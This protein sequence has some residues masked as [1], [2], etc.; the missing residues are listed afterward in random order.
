MIRPDPRA[1]DELIRKIE[2][3]APESFQA[4]H[5]DLR[6]TVTAG[7]EGVLA[8]M[9]LVTREEFEVQAQLLARCQQQLAELQQRLGER[10]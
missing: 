10:N 5:D 4:V 6:K 1:L 7:V 3:L 8:R 9:N 2:T